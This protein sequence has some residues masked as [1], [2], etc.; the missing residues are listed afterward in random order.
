MASNF[1][2]GI[3]IDSPE[4]SSLD[5]IDQ[6]I[7]DQKSKSTTNREKYD[8][9]NFS[10]FRKINFTEVRSIES[11]PAEELDNLLS[12]FFIKAK[13]KQGKLYEPDTLNCIRN[14][15]QRVLI[16]KGSKMNIRDDMEFCRSRKVLTARRKQLTKLG[17][18]NK[19]NATRALT[20]KEVDL[21]YSSKYFGSSTPVSLQ[22]TIWWIITTNFGHRARN[23]AR[24]LLFGDIKIKVSE[25]TEY[26]E[27]DTERATKTR[28]GS[29][30][31]GHKR[32]FNPTAF[33]TGTER[34]PV[35]FYKNYI[36][37]RPGNMC[38]DA[39]PLFLAINYYVDYSLDLVWY[40]PRP[41]GKN[42]IGEFL[43]GARKVLS[44][45]EGSTKG[46]IS[47]HSARKTTITNLLDNNINP[48]YVQQLSGHKRM[49]SLNTYHVPSIK[50]QKEM[51]HVVSGYFNKSSDSPKYIQQSNDIHKKSLNDINNMNIC[52][53]LAEE[54][55]NPWD[56][57]N[58][59]NNVVTKHPAPI[60][61]NCTF[62]FGIMPTNLTAETANP[63]PPKRRR[64]LTI[65][66]S[67]DNEN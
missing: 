59:L 7:N 65:D 4:K 26:L 14:S 24:Q 48:L 60:F 63:L 32:A 39:S 58:L 44:S 34:C 42:K 20:E 21:L 53:S 12:H 36:S 43:P 22:R 67:S 8:L 2:L 3:V 27:W 52:P 56:P 31:M 29:V 30:P 38:K 35:S 9:K 49:E 45:G 1:N 41:L 37:H 55:S 54:M 33:A 18:G 17:K 50:Q 16:E 57:V 64:I 66:D 15:L 51:S 11:I 40:L 46:K 19:P 25:G 5:F 13:T 6:F 28:D 62:N 61:N 10:S 47:N 23:E